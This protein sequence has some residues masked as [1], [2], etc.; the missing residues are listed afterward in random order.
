MRLGFLGAACVLSMIT[1]VIIQGIIGLN[2]TS[3]E[4]K[5]SPSDS[6][7]HGKLWVDP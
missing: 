2:S 6:V 4:I 1:F 7:S 3:Y 5:T